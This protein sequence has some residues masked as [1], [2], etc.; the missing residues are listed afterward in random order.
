MDFSKHDNETLDS[1]KVVNP[2]VWLLSYFKS[3]IITNFYSAS[4]D[5]ESDGQ[6]LVNYT[7]KQ[8]PVLLL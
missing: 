7:Y 8:L 4:G 1:I 3:K 6:I 2:A 5:K